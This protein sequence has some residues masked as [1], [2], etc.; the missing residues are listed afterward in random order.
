MYNCIN[1]IFW[2]TVFRFIESELRRK[3]I[4]RR[5]L[6][7]CFSK[8]FLWLLTWRMKIFHCKL[9]LFLW[10]GGLNRGPDRSSPFIRLLHS[11]GINQTLQTKEFQMVIIRAEAISVASQ[12][13]VFMNATQQQHSHF[14]FYFLCHFHISV[15]I[16]LL[17]AFVVSPF[18]YCHGFIFKWTNFLF[19]YD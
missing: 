4:I 8:S 2:R 14:S 13:S 19:D 3:Q 1:D 5:V 12:N 18:N 10:D 7:W 11:S 17:Q 6:T 16:T 15:T 9:I